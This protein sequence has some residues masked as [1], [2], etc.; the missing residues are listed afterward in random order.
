[1]AGGEQAILR[2]IAHYLVSSFRGNPVSMQ[3]T[4]AR[5]EGW[6]EINLENE[7]RFG[8]FDTSGSFSAMYD[9]MDVW[10]A[11]FWTL[12]ARVTGKGTDRLVVTTWTQA[13]APG[14]AKEFRRDFA[15]SLVSI[16]T[17]SHGRESAEHVKD[18]LRSRGFKI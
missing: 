14:H 5:V 11:V 12:R 6:R 16:T 2:A 18:L 4:G 8:R 7:R 1:M 9:E 17:E 10:G 3:K 13:H 15:G